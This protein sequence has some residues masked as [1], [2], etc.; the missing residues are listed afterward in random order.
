MYV[1]ASSSQLRDHGVWFYACDK[2]GCDAANIRQW[3]GDFSNINNVAT[4]M[5]R[6]GQCFSSTQV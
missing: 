2:Q 6:M 3:M 5:A 1:A 4:R